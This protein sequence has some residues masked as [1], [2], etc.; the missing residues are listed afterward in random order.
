MKEKI[1]RLCWN[2][3]DW[4]RPSGSEGKSLS[5]NSYEK[6]VGF[7]IENKHTR[8]PETVVNQEQLNPE[9]ARLE[10]KPSTENIYILK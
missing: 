7:G 5:E 3:H 4:K 9:P 10:K 2:T 6:I 8:E 1:A